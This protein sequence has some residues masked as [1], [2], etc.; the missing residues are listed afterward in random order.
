MIYSFELFVNVI[1]RIC[2]FF[3]LLKLFNMLFFL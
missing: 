1:I 2:I 3:Y